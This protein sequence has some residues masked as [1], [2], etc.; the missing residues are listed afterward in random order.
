MS[1]LAPDS[2]AMRAH[3]SPMGPGPSTTTQSP[4]WIV[5]F[6]HIAL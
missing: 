1:G 5:A 2:A 4:G 3:S 6:P